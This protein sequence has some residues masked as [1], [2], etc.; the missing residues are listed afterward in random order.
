MA[1]TNAKRGYV[2]EDNRNFS[3]EA[4]AMLRTASRHVRCLINEGYDLK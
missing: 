2:P 3:E 1:G 4:V